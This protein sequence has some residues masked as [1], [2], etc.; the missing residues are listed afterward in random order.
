MDFGLICN[1]MSEVEPKLYGESKWC[2]KGCTARMVIEFCKLR[3]TGVCIMH[4]GH[5][6]ESLAGPN[7]IVAALHE[8]HLYFYRS[9][10]TRKKLM[11]WKRE[12]EKHRGIKLKKEHRPNATTPPA[13][14]WR[15][16]A[17]KV[18]PGHF[19][20]TEEDMTVVRAWFLESR[21]CPRIALKDMNAIRSLTYNCTKIDAAKGSMTVHTTPQHYQEI[22]E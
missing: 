17:H 20:T 14:E 5:V 15:L 13:S 16:F 11:T 2:E 6:L 8:N 10:K 1:E 9:M 19:Y 22:M 18:E 21:R 7:P 4:N 3:N 12:D